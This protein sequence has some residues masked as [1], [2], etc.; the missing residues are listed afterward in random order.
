MII[1]NNL[2]LILMIYKWVGFS[3]KD[4]AK[5]L[6]IDKFNENEDYKIN[7]NNHLLIKSNHRRG[8]NKE[9][10]FLTLNCFKKFCINAKTKDSNKIYDLFTINEKEIFKYINL[11]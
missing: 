11:L 4:H 5:R 8:R 10:I 2:L 7:T 9:I 1:Q 6:L 3:R